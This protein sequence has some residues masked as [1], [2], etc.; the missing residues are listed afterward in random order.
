MVFSYNLESYIRSLEEVGSLSPNL[1]NK[2]GRTKVLYIINNLFAMS[3]GC[4]NFPVKV[5]RGFDYDAVERALEQQQPVSLADEACYVAL[6]LCIQDYRR[7][8][9]ANFIDGQ[10]GCYTV[11]YEYQTF[12]FYYVLHPPTPVDWERDSVEEMIDKHTFWDRL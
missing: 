5:P 10:D 1:L 12:P 9:V 3:V 6:Q 11:D 8:F 2:L 4:S 7:M